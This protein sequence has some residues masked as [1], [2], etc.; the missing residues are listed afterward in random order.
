MM[1]S[2][3]IQISRV[4][5]GKT[6]LSLLSFILSF[7]LFLPAVHA[8]NEKTIA[9]VMKALS[10]PFFSK[11][12]EGARSYANQQKIPLEVFGVERE[13]DVERQISIFEN[14]IARGYGAIVI[15][16]AD[17]KKLVAVCKKA[18]E[19]NIIVINIDNPL[20]QETM[21]KAGIAIPFVGS[22]NYLGASMVGDY[23][24]NKLNGGGRVLVIEGIRGVENAELRKNGFIDTVTRDSEIEVVGSESANWHRDEAF[25]LVTSLLQQ[26][27]SI[28]AIFCANDKMALGALQALD[29]TGLT[30]KT[31]LAGYD[32]I[33]SVR[34]EMRNGRIRATV[35]Q[36][37]ELMGEYGV[38]LARQA[39]NGQK[40]A[41]FE[42]TPL[43]LVTHESFNKKIALSI[44][45][46]DN[47]FFEILLNGAKE[48]AQ[49]NGVELKF[50]DAHNDEA[51]QLIDT[52]RLIQENVDILV[53]NPT[54]TETIL[55]G[56]E[57]ANKRGVPVITVDRK[58]E[59]GNVLCHV[60][61]DN[62]EG[63]RLAARI[64]ATHLN[65]KG[66]IIELEGIPGTSATQDRGAG[67]NRELQNYP[68]IDV[69]MREAANF[70]REDAK[71]LMEYLVRQNVEFDAIFAHNDNMILGVIEALENNN[72]KTKP[73][74]VGFDAIP[75]AVEAV[76][77][78]KLTATIAQ[79]PSAMGRLSIAA[80]VRYF[81]G[82][83]L[84]SA[85]DV[86]LSVVSQ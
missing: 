6:M 14:L 15:A 12:E 31:L 74:L 44:S 17:S 2:N 70:E 63:G 40:V 39:L 69:V 1:R 73:V 62:I 79:Q 86:D 37:P 13:T 76:K 57:M 55:P 7:M 11:M 43:D 72:I 3:N 38:R 8:G 85:I 33:E 18:V 59:G 81:R 50:I 47:Q 28:D 51:Q 9:L 48:A 71:Q 58:A 5:S 54:N 30:G 68:G 16:P 20:H 78:G 61:S 67:F 46:L 19:K 42:K 32:N 22:D 4:V 53:I 45:T 56:I 80:A 26:H 21:K 82:E 41:S 75:E 35:E 77:L 52:S 25:S 27:K 34:N 64:L 84:P 24:K 83:V 36:H 49:L 66:K 60:S 29:S 23:V 10:N 65:N